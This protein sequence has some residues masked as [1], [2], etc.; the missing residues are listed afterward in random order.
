MWPDEP[1]TIFTGPAPNMP[2]VSE[3]DGSDAGFG[4]LDTVIALAAVSTL[5]AIMPH[6]VLGSGELVARAEAGVGATQAMRMAAASELAEGQ[7][8][9]VRLGQ[10]GGR[11]WR[12]VSRTVE[13][14]RGEDADHPMALQTTSLVIALD[15]GRT[16]TIEGLMVGRE[17]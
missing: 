3:K 15:A 4:L 5:L 2:A 14:A 8:A 10:A 17:P 12:A 16:V 11:T 1:I 13:V 6:A 7:D 9:T